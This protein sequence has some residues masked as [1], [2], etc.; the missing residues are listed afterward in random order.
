MSVFHTIAP[1]DVWV[2]DHLYIW[3]SGKHQHHG[4]VLTVDPHDPSLSK[5][6]QFGTDDDG[7]RAHVKVVTLN[8]FHKDCTLKRVLYGSRLTRFRRT[9]TAYRIKSLAPEHV[10]D[11]AQLI[12]EQIKFGDEFILSDG[13]DD[14]YGF[15]L[16]LR[17]CECLA[18]WC[19]TGR[20]YYEQ[21]GPS[22]EN[23][24]KPL[25][26]FMKGIFDGLG[27]ADLLPMGGQGR[28]RYGEDI[29]RTLCE[30][31]LS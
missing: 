28:I 20:W 2:G 6:L 9:G 29:S 1:K 17:N 31:Y 15:N 25:L 26:T 30:H 11:N 8:Q 22:M 19:K 14:A 18:Y 23:F 3:S 7:R 4:L 13:L 16:V 12:L 21:V 5:V 10:L 24:N 27:R